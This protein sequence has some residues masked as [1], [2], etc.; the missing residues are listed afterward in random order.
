MKPSL[1]T[2]ALRRRRSSVRSEARRANS[3]L[4]HSGVRVRRSPGSITTPRLRLAAFAQT[5]KRACR[6]YIAR[7]AQGPSAPGDMDSGLA[8][9]APRNDERIRLSPNKH[10]QTAEDTPPHSRCAIRARVMPKVALMEAEGAGNAGCFA[11]PAALCA[12]AESTQAYSPQVQPKHRHSLRDGVNGLYRARPGET[13]FCVTV[14]CR[15][16]DPQV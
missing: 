4:R 9:R 3:L 7:M 2:A 15:I 8:L 14:A 12:I 16:I 6:L 5:K 1:R 10:F 11:A 13:G